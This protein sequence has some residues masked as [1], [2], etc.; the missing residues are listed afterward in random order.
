M[1]V[2]WLDNYSFIT[3][4]SDVTSCHA[5][6]QQAIVTTPDRKMTRVTWKWRQTDLLRTN[7]NYYFKEFMSSCFDSSVNK[8]ARTCLLAWVCNLG[9]VMIKVCDDEKSLYENKVWVSLFILLPRAYRPVSLPSSY[10]VYY[11]CCTLYQCKRCL[12]YGPWNIILY[13]IL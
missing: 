4:W 7:L 10:S 2:C 11:K 12:Y 8:Q 9:C 1:S 3:L 5:Q 13:F 6:G